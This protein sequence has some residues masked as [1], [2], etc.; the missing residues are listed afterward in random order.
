MANVWKESDPYEPQLGKILEAVTP[1]ISQE[2]K[3]S[4]ILMPCQWRAGKQFVEVVPYDSR[5]R[6]VLEIARL[7][8]SSAGKMPDNAVLY[9][10]PVRTAKHHSCTI[11][12]TDLRQ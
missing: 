6:T 11:F 4:A 3:M 7:F 5:A 9:K 1:Y 8:E 10:S 2:R 12:A